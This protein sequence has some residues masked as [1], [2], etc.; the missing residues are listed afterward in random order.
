MQFT[1]K[2]S[3]I[4]NSCGVIQLS[5]KWMR[6]WLSRLSFRANRLLHTS[7]EYGFTPVFL[8]MKRIEWFSHN[9]I[10]NLISTYMSPHVY[11]H[12][13]HRQCPHFAHV[14]FHFQFFIVIL[15]VRMKR[16]WI[17]KSFAALFALISQDFCLHSNHQ[18]EISIHFRN[19]Y[20]R[21]WSEI[22]HM[23]AHM[24]LQLIT[25]FA[26]K[27]AFEALIVRTILMLH[28][29]LAQHFWIAQI[30][31]TIIA[32]NLHLLSG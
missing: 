17:E 23:D 12:I 15:E 31:A 11:H 28:A 27:F 8:E 22:T 26:N 9:K 14:A 2:C 16:T 18:R 32:F 3:G 5:R 7:H 19:V 1:N 30:N 20:A 4:A 25:R 21:W 10:S 29:V 24:G 6:K 13:A